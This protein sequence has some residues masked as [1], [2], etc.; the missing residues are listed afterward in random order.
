MIESLEIHKWLPEW[1]RCLCTIRCNLSMFSQAQT[2]ASPEHFLL[3]PSLPLYMA[4]KLT[5]S[6]VKLSLELISPDRSLRRHRCSPLEGGS[7]AGTPPYRGWR[8]R[9]AAASPNP[10][11]YRWSAAFRPRTTPRRPQCGTIS[12]RPQR[13]NSPRWVDHFWNILKHGVTRHDLLGRKCLNL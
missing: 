12:C 7:S 5:V 9:Q 6:I 11:S 3:A 1:Y 8:T 10:S 4:E 2:Q 13:R